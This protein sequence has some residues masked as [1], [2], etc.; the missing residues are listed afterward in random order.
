[1]AAAPS[2]RLLVHSVTLQKAAFTPSTSGA[3]VPTWTTRT[4]SVACLVSQ[5]SPTAENRERV[6]VTHLSQA[7]AAAETSVGDRLL[8][9][10]GPGLTAGK[11]FRVTGI[12]R[13]GPFGRIAG[14]TRL[15]CEETHEGVGPQPA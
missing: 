1:M 6:T 3:S 10:T 8:V 9:V 13:H 5:G 2:S 4:A 11:Y 15:E 7:T 14:F 12:S